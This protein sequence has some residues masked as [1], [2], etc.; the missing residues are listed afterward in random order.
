T[1]AAPT[2]SESRAPYT[3]RLQTSRPT[4]SVP[5]QWARPGADS[6]RATS[7]WPGSL[8][9]TG[10][11]ALTSTITSMSTAPASVV[12][13]RVISASQP[14]LA[15]RG[16]GSARGRAITLIAVRAAAHS[17]DRANRS[18]LV[19]HPRVEDDVREVDHEVDQHVHAGD[20]Q[21]DSLD[22]RVVAPQ[23]RRDDQPAQARDVEHRLHHDRPR[24]QDRERDADDGNRRD[25]RVLERVLVDDRPL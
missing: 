23:H 5:N 1:T 19:A 25:H 8:A 3:T 16:T 4:S 15:R 10:A 13:R 12:L 7:M 11:S 21:H 22:D 24:D 14:G 20:A 9:S 2:S 6:R 18:S 17:R